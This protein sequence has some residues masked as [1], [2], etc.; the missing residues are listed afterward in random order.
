MVCDNYGVLARKRQ[1][2]FRRGN[3]LRYSELCY[4]LDIA[5]ESGEEWDL[6]ELGR[7]EKYEQD[8]KAVEELKQK[9]PD[10]H[11]ELRRGIK[12][13]CLYDGVTVPE[14]LGRMGKRRL[15]SIYRGL[16]EGN[17]GNHRDNFS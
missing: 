8:R 4:Q 3:A 1:D 11:R 17:S 12:Q 10:T 5:P 7:G 6:F 15:C 14:G 16:I 9:I 13:I 2:A